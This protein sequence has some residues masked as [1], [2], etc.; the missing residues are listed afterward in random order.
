MAPLY[1]TTTRGAT[2][3]TLAA[4]YQLRI[5]FSTPTGKYQ[6]WGSLLRLTLAAFTKGESQTISFQISLHH[7]HLKSRLDALDRKSKVNLGTRLNTSKSRAVT[8]QWLND[9]EFITN[10][11]NTNGCQ[12]KLSS[13]YHQAFKNQK[14]LMKMVIY[15]NTGNANS[16]L[17]KVSKTW[18][19]LVELL[20]QIYC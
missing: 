17:S 7:L 16:C 3:D 1:A 20:T 5:A 19:W 12:S 9:I 11:K 6:S 14:G 2:S 8:F 18:T 15:N 13:Q 4:Y 10:I